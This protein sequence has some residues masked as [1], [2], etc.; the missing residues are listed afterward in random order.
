MLIPLQ[1]ALA[2]CSTRSESQTFVIDEHRFLVPQQ[3]LLP[4]EVAWFPSLR[5]STGLLFILDP[6][7]P[8]GRRHS[9]LVESRDITC[10]REN[11]VASEMT[12]AACDESMEW[13]PQGTAL[14]KELSFPGNETFW[15]YTV[16]GNG[17]RRIVLASCYA[18]ATGEAAG[19][20]SA[21]GR[22]SSL[23]YSFS[24]DDDDVGQLNEYRQKIEALLATWR[25][26]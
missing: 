3:V 7:Q 24:V 11:I 6:T 14:R 21:F 23:V 18:P 19:A 9:V 26:A 25:Q 10:R 12:A 8:V 15:R 1:L 2:S 13:P 4:S 20:C 22:Y 17:G 5:K 16:D